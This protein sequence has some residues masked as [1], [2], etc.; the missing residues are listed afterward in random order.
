MN[1]AL[2]LQ[3]FKCFACGLFNAMRHARV[4]WLCSF[5][6]VNWMLV[7]MWMQKQTFDGGE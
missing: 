5:V 4:E 7:M 6:M 1:L 2:N 3:A